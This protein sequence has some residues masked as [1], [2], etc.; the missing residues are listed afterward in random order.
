MYSRNEKRHQRIINSSS[1]LI[2][3]QFVSFGFSFHLKLTFLHYS[4]L[5][6]LL[7]VN[8]GLVFGSDVYTGLSGRYLRLTFSSFKSQKTVPTYFMI[9]EFYGLV[10]EKYIVK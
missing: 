6:M 2:L 3:D 4:K 10:Y 8:C 9:T 5:Q 1:A 7:L